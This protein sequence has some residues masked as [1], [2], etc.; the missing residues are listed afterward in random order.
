MITVSETPRRQW[1]FRNNERT[2]K[3]AAVPQV[4]T[5]EMRIVKIFAKTKFAIDADAVV[6]CRPSFVGELKQDGSESSQPTEPLHR[7]AGCAS[8]VVQKHPKIAPLCPRHQI[9]A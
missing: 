2:S 6:R 3:K 1:R 8:F 4:S 7:L 9:T 5:F